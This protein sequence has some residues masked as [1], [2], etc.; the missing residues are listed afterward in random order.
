MNGRV[1]VVITLASNEFKVFSLLMMK[2]MYHIKQVFFFHFF[3]NVRFYSLKSNIWSKYHK[4]K[5]LNTNT[6]FI[7][8]CRLYSN[9]ALVKAAARGVGATANVVLK[10]L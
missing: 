3:Y 7:L 9:R 4:R 2:A 5:H 1:S 6:L 10:A 8:L